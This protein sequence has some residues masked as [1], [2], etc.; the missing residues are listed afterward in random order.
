MLATRRS[1]FSTGIVWCDW[2]RREGKTAKYIYIRNKDVQWVWDFHFI[3]HC[4][5]K[6][7]AKIYAMEIYLDSL[8]PW[9]QAKIIKYLHFISCVIVQM[10]QISSIWE[11]WKWQC[12]N[13]TV[14]KNACWQRDLLPTSKSNGKHNKH[15][16]YYVKSSGSHTTYI[17]FTPCECVQAHHIYN[18]FA[19]K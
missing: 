18:H 10:I 1:S 2:V 4:G 6:K 19:R 16:A 7:N 3:N 15:N 13:Q 5:L 9:I 14:C 12:I 17:G 8:Q 11:L